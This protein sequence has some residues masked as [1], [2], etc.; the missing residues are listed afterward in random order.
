M[1]YLTTYQG[2][3]AATATNRD[4][5]QVFLLTADRTADGPTEIAL[6]APQTVTGQ[7]WYPGETVSID[8]NGTGSSTPT[9]AVVDSSGSLSGSR[10]LRRLVLTQD[11]GAAITGPGRVDVFFGTGERRGLEAGSM[12][13]RGELNVGQLCREKLGADAY[14]VGFGTDHGT[15]AAAS[16]WDAPMQR[17][18]VRPSRPDSYERIFHQS[19]VPAFLTHLR[20]PRREELRDELLPSR[21]E[22]AIGVIY[23]PETERQSHYFYARLADQFDAVLHFDETRALEPLERTATWIAGEV[24]ETYPFAV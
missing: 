2:A 19:G 5:D 15:V 20:E 22:R 23:R 4:E 6:A 9:T 16:N 8:D 1:N 24:P 10:P 17:M 13:E 18:S 7:N 11:T 12:S 14:I 3:D 21:L